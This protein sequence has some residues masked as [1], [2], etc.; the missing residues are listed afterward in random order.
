MFIKVYSFF[1]FLYQVFGIFLMFKDSKSR[2]MFIAFDMWWKPSNTTK[3]HHS[4]CAASIALNS[5]VYWRKVLT[6]RANQ[7]ITRTCRFGIKNSVWEHIKVAQN[8]IKAP[9]YLMATV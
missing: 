6:G 9:V 4:W 2:I 5:I 7:N 3:R 8:A 1:F